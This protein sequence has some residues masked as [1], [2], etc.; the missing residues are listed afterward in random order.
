MPATQYLNLDFDAIKASIKDYLRANSN[1]TD[2]DF[3]GSNL[4]ILIDVLSYN[5]FLN[6]YNTNMVANESFMGSA[7]LRDNVVAHADNIGYLPRSSRSA[8][9]KISFSVTFENDNTAASLT[10]KK[11]QVAVS[12]IDNSNYTFSVLEDITVPINNLKAAFSGIDIYEGLVITRSFLVDT[13][14]KDQKFI[15]DNQK[16]DTSTIRVRVKKSASEEIYTNYRSVENII[17]SDS[18]SNIFLVKE[19]R[20]ETYQLIFGDGVIGKKLEN[21]NIV[22]VT[23]I[24]CNEDGPNGQQNFVINGNLITDE[25]VRIASSGILPV[26]NQPSIGGSKL[27]SVDSIKKYASRYLATQ[28]RAVTSADYETLIP[29]I[30]PKAE[31]AVAYGGETLTPPQYG[32]VF[33]SIKPDSS[34][35]LS[36]FDKNFLKEE[37]KKYSPI[38]LDIVIDDLEYLYIELDVNAYYSTNLTSNPDAV[39]SKIFTVLETYAQTNDITRFGGRFKYSQATAL[40]DNTDTSITSNITNVVLRRNQQPTFNAYVSYELCFGN[41]IFAPLRSF[42]NIKSTGFKVD[43][44]REVVYFADE[45][46]STSTGDLWIFR[47]DGDT[48][49]FL[50]KVGTVDYQAGELFIDSLNITSSVLTSN[51]IEVECLPSSFD[52][53]G[54]RNLFLDIAVDSSTVNMIKDDVSSG[55]DTSGVNFSV[56]PQYNKQ[57]FFRIS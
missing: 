20:D 25:G 18:N 1:F 46:V 32:K 14:Q 44:Y 33:V 7:T 15:L 5:T 10:L 39:K 4:S 57:G 8:K 54:K 36:L 53:L 40:I 12:N 42:Y 28:N 45:A 56:T 55:S 23:Y 19:Y 9:S 38:G 2:Y 13:S 35:F 37:L 41:T 30:F 51:V 43:K 34:S 47:M 6:S 26:V 48:P 49:E 21:G 27:E 24:V 17:G 11:G 3:E 50:E 16:I 31:S 52:I 29:K 22:E